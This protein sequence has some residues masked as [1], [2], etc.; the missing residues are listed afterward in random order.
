[1]KNIVD[2]ENCICIN[3]FT[4]CEIH[5]NGEV[6]PCCPAWCNY[7]S[8]GNVFTT[9]FDK[10]WNGEKAVYFRKKMI[11]NDFSF[12]NR[13]LCTYSSG[14]SEKD[15]LNKLKEKYKD[16]L[17]KIEI[18]SIKMCWERECNVA[19]ITCRNSIIRNS[20]EDLKRCEQIK[21]NLLPYLDSLKIFYCSGSGDPL[22]STY[23]RNLIKE[24]AS[25]N[26]EVKF[27]LHTNGI[28]ATKEML[29]KLGIKDR[30][31]SFEISVHATTKE[32]YDKIVKYGNFDRVIENIKNIHKYYKGSLK[33]L[34]VLTFV[35][36]DY[37]YKEIPDFIKFAKSVNA[38]VCF[39]YF[40]YWGTEFGRGEQ[41]NKIAVWQPEHPEFNEFLKII[42][43]PTVRNCDCYRHADFANLIQKS[44]KNGLLNKIVTF[45]KRIF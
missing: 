39:Y 30:I 18:D 43:S 8:F 4:Y 45:L 1:M 6:Y 25:I 21:R 11:E 44:T 34:F 33:D 40:R 13:N 17:D 15:K 7:Y 19:C 35:I 5:L 10:I 27:G 42:N 32:T 20:P 16:N 3:P 26:K 14:C 28:L 37:N 9:P 36:T 2:K 38:K 29:E 31:F 22:A 23:C 41:I 12:C 24:L